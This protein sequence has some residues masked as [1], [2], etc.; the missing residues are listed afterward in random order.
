MVL[1]D[2]DR[3]KQL[4]DRFGRELGND[5]LTTSAVHC[6]QRLRPND[7]IHRLGGDELLIILSGRRELLAGGSS[8]DFGPGWRMQQRARSP[9]PLVWHRRSQAIVRLPCSVARTNGCA[10]RRRGA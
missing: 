3:F 2:R 7:V 1:V 6:W 9:L 5:V 10:M 8:S 4:N